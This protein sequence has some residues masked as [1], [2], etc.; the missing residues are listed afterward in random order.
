VARAR[1]K[2]S[3]HPAPTPETAAPEAL[4]QLLGWRFRNPELL[5]SALRH[6]SLGGRSGQ[7]AHH[8]DRFEFL[9]DRVVGLVAAELLLER[10]PDDREGA[11]ARRHATLVNR[12][13]LARM[14]RAINLAR[15]LILSPG[16]AKAGGGDN[17]AVLSDAFEAV[18]AALYLDGGLEPARTFLAAQFEPLID[19]MRAPPR[20]AK[21]ALQEWAQGHGFRLP[22]YRT[23]EMSGPAHRPR[24]VVEVQIEGLAHETAQGSSRRAAEQTA[25]AALL[26]R[27]LGAP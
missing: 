18:V 19:G 16:E 11:V 20:D 22:A 12:E 7:S 27:V 6:S 23:L 14:A 25:A 1:H 5:R 9:G 21:T 3:E 2:R 24:I 17:P 13:S 26:S 8:F 15:F 10:H 4:E